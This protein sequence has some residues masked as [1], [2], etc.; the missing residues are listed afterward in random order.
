MRYSEDARKAGKKVTPGN[1]VYYTLKHL[2]SGRRS[3]GQST[4]DPLHPA[5]LLR[6][7]SRVHSLEERI[8]GI[9]GD[10]TSGEPMTIG[11]ALASQRDDPATEASRQLDWGQVIDS[12]DNVS[13]EILRGLVSGSKLPAPV[14]RLGRSQSSLQ[15][16]KKRLA[17]LIRE[18]LGDD[19]LR[20]VRHSR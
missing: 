6:G 12:V 1:I 9:T 3:T 19:I 17:K 2:R 11:E 18:R 5:T 7:R 4:T 14:A 13:R 16:A 20:Q 8:V 10:E 15:C